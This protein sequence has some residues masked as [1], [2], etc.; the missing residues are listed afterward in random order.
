MS[1]ITTPDYK[2]GDLRV[3]EP[4]KRPRM[5]N[6]RDRESS[7]R[8]YHDDRSGR[9]LPVFDHFCEWLCIAV[10]LRTMK[11]YLYV[12]A[13]LPVD[14]FATSI[15]IV[16]ALTTSPM[17]TTPARFFAIIALP[18]LLLAVVCAKSSLTQWKHIAF[19]NETRHQPRR[20]L[21]AYK[22]TFLN[23]RHFS[24]IYET[25]GN[26]WDLGQAENIRQVLGSKWWMW[27]LFFWQ[28]ERV[29]KYGRYKPA[30]DLPFSVNVLQMRGTILTY[31]NEPVPVARPTLSEAPTTTRAQGRRRASASSPSHGE[32]SSS[33]R[34]N[35]R[36]IASEPLPAGYDEM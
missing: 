31:A 9:C 6:M 24:Y 11:P 3:W 16:V 21:L 28:P 8:V 36:K 1:L 17:G 15:L 25:E 23:D 35:T 32:G 13:L 30:F 33:R 12:L 27:L 26:P 5:C 19:W 10:Y 22:I 7:D 20:E 4:T 2:A 34:R 18:V 29:A 14:L